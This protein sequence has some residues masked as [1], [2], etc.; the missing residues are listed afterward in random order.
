MSIFSNNLV[1]ILKGILRWEVIGVITSLIASIFAWSQ[2]KHDKGGCLEVSHNTQKVY[3]NESKDLVILTDSKQIYFTDIF[4][5]FSNSDKYSLRDFTLSHTVEMNG[6]IADNTGFYSKSDINGHTYLLKYSEDILPPHQIVESPI[7]SIKLLEAETALCVIKSKATWDG[8]DIPFEFTTN[9]YIYY[10]KAFENETFDSWKNRCKKIVNANVNLPVYDLVYL[11][12]RG[13]ES[14]E[15]NISL[16][17]IY[18]SQELQS[19]KTDDGNSEKEKNRRQNQKPNL[20]KDSDFLTFYNIDSTT[21]ENDKI[22]TLSYNSA[23]PKEETTFITYTLKTPKNR[24]VEGK[25]V[26]IKPGSGSVILSLHKEYCLEQYLGIAHENCKLSDYII[27]EN[28]TLRNINDTQYIGVF[29]IEKINNEYHHHNL[30][31]APQ[32]AITLGNGNKNI[33]INRV[34]YYN[35]DNSLLLSSPELKQKI[36][37]TEEEA[38]SWSFWL[39]LGCWILIFIIYLIYEGQTRDFFKYLSLFIKKRESFLIRWREGIEKSWWVERN[40]ARYSLISIL[41]ITFIITKLY[42]IF[43]LLMYIVNLIVLIW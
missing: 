13:K 20:N 38:H 8:A 10:L 37:N 9:T 7:S 26:N 19:G 28:R 24:Y 5:V 22:Y 39:L 25:R 34:Q 21:T 43:C 11:S 32:S 29:L 35:I 6:V 36:S 1:K 3:S 41:M 12:S 16:S 30:V 40:T 2:F 23:S 15:Y 27:F 4:P 17:Q 33:E 14:R 31:I 42:T 18:Y